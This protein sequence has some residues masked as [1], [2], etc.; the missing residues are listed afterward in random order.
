MADALIGAL[1]R[2]ASRAALAVSVAGLTLMTLIIGWQVFARYVLN[3]SPSWSEQAAL[4]LMLYF[5]L[6]A[7][8]VGVREGF[9]IRITLLEDGLSKARRKWLR[10]VNH[11]MVG[12]FGFAMAAGG[13]ELIGI[14]GSH[15]I[16]TLG[17][18]RA[19]AFVPMAGAGLLILFFSVEHILAEARGRKVEP[20]WS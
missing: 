2:I 15:S 10:L 6:F 4:L 11:L 18:S 8:A 20:I 7:A 5:L 9:H 19:F 3:A 12:I 17:I 13:L 16:S 1:S 14:T